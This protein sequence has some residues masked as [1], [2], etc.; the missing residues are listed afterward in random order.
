MSP[1][2]RSN[3]SVRAYWNSGSAPGWLPTSE[4]S[5][6]SSAGFERHADLLGRSQ[7]RC[8][9][10]LG[11]QIGDVHDPS[12]EPGP[13]GRVCQ[14]ESVEVGP[15]CEHDGDPVVRI[16]DGGHQIREEAVPHGRVVDEREQFLELI[17]HQHQ[18]RIV[19]G[20]QP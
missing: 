19:L 6:P 15:Q 4:I 11:G 12:A 20:E 7:R 18:P 14:R 2:R 16:L 3:S 9:Q 17:D 5:W 13:E 8:L 1:T 10:L